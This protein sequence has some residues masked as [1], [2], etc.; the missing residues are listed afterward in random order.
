MLYFTR[1]G[2]KIIRTTHKFLGPIAD[3][4]NEK[5]QDWDQGGCLLNESLTGF[6]S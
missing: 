1:R 6:L 5:V 2:K 3:P 4:L